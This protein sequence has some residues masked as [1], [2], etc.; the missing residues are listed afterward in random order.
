MY[1]FNKVVWS[2]GLFLQPQIFQQQERYLEHLT[3]RRALPLSPFFWGFGVLDVDS[4]ALTLGKL[5]LRAAEGIFQDGTP[6]QAPAHTL[7][8]QPLAVTPALAGQI[9]C[10]TLPLKSPGSH[11]ISFDEQPLSSCRYS[12]SEALVEDSNSMGKEAQTVQTATLRLRLTTEA[13]C[14]GDL[15]TLAVARVQEVRGDGSV[16]LDPDFVP[17]VNA[18][19]ASARVTAWLDEL[20]GLMRLRGTAL[21]E[22]LLQ[23]SDGTVATEVADHL[24]LQVLN[25]HE[26]LLE[27]MVNSRHTSP[28]QLYVH[29]LSLSGEL[30]TFLRFQTRRPR[31]F[32]PYDHGRPGLALQALVEDLRT[33]LH[34]VFERGALR[35]PLE[36][37]GFG[38]RVALL[39]E[40]MGNFSALVLCVAAQMPRD[41][42]VQEFVAKTKISTPDR[43]PQ[44]MRSH[45]PG[46]ALQTLPV[47]PRQIP[48]HVGNMYFELRREGALWDQI[49][50]SG[51]LALHVAGDFPGL[52][53]ELWGTRQS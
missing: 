35:I 2:E 32:P 42:L 33:L 39:P 36:E 34:V 4:D 3:H 27:Y 1:W 20:Y 53:L 21:A 15:L 25:R 13:Q 46:L 52:H 40:N 45:L 6:F 14:G 22:S 43:L 23:A 51:A 16:V 29:L 49:R 10:L 18:C 7:L 47:A 11:E 17:P 38:Q 28:E 44:L 8:P 41:V 50:Q 5:S 26:P 9:I 12:T 48:F 24:L 30:S 19:G 37:K 31:P